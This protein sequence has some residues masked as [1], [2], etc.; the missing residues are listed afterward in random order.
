MEAVETALRQCK[1]LLN[2]DAALQEQLA[3]SEARL[4]MIWAQLTRLWDVSIGC[5]HGKV[6][7]NA[8]IGHRLLDICLERPDEIKLIGRYHGLNS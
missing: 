6:A 3:M 2:A 4:T 1:H 7:M 5:S 8:A